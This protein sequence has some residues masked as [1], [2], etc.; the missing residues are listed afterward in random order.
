M[1]TINHPAFKTVRE[2]PDE[3]LEK[4]LAAGWEK[5]PDVAA[6]QSIPDQGEASTS[7]DSD[8]TKPRGR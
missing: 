2:V 8:K 7:P 6:D 4:W 1:A 3:S 5:A